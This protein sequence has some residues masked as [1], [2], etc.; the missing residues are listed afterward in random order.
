MLESGSRNTS[1]YAVEWDG[2]DT[3]KGTVRMLTDIDRGNVHV[4]GL[5]AITKIVKKKTKG[6]LSK[7]PKVVTMAGRVKSSLGNE[8]TE[9]E[10]KSLD[11]LTNA[12]TKKH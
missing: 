10:K 9:L 4:R 5:I 7:S 6:S 11:K 1:I 12:R 8:E 2:G 3:I